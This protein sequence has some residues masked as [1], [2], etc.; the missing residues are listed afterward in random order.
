MI[1]KALIFFVTLIIFEG[2]LFAKEKARLI[3]LSDIR[4]KRYD[5]EDLLKK[6]PV[7]VDFW[8][9]WCKPC[10][11]YFPHLERMHKKY[12]GEGL[13]IIGINEDGPRNK[14]KIRSFLRS[15]NISFPNLI[16]ETAE[17]MSDYG[18]YSLPTWFLIGKDGYIVRIH[19][20]YIKGDEN[21]LENEIKSL[22]FNSDFSKR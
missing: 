18:V 2:E 1:Y 15:L 3:K 20:G 5:L 6:G 21:L 8:A 13:S 19:K 11:E 12:E 9:T 16:D 7:L 22:L 14:R 10:K 4:G 17:V